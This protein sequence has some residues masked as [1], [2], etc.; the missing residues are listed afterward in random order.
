[1]SEVSASGLAHHFDDH[2]QQHEAATLGMWAF[3]VTE[4]LFFGGLF[5]G[6]AAS[7]ATPTRKPSPHASDTLSI[8]LGRSTPPC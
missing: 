8:L 4:V 1:M 3:L 5:A 7:T 2:E 6:Y